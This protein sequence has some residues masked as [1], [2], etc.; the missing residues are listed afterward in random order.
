MT[1]VL[2]SSHINYVFSHEFNFILSIFF[3]PVGDKDSHNNADHTYACSAQE[4]AEVDPVDKE[5]QTD[6]CAQ[7]SNEKEGSA[8]KNKAPQ[9]NFFTY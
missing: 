6:P 1:T 3:F 4:G 8:D 2:N 9:V 5:V 7:S